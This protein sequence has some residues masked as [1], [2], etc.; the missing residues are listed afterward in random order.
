MSAS[1]APCLP[2]LVQP[3][4]PTTFLER[5]VAV[6]FT[7]PMLA[8]ARARPGERAGA[9]LIVPNPSGGQGVYI[10]PWAGVCQLC[11]PTVH[12]RRLNAKVAALARVTPSTIRLAALEVAAEGLAGRA[13]ASA[14]TANRE[15]E[16]EDRLL[17]NF[18]L[19]L[20]LIEQVEPG[21]L[22]LAD[23]GRRRTAALEQRARRAVS[24]IAPRLGGTPETIA[25]ALEGIADVHAAIGLPR[26]DRPPRIPRLLA[27]LHRTRAELVTWGRDRMDD[28][29]VASAASVIG[30]VADV[31]LACA[32]RALTDVQ[33]AMG[34][35]PALLRDWRASPAWLAARAARP[36]WLLD[37]WEPICLRWLCA[38]NE[39]AR[40]E[41]V[42]DIMRLVPILPREVA[43]WVG[44][45]VDVRLAGRTRRLVR[46]NEDWRADAM[47]QR[48][49]RNEQLRALAA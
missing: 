27:M 13:A 25:E 24:R 41:A 7:T 39:A 1:A 47:L 8:G 2:N 38:E 18:L 31:T 46:P 6:P 5:G 11:Q 15:I 10:L 37:G 48:I 4:Q 45:S 23:V 14:A 26:Q 16:R 22:G 36:E 3:C 44:T 40:R 17:L 33:A 34:D 35:V 29:G 21:G 49:A 19:L 12:D 20:A 43:D 32:R 9:E 42:A 30:T 28:D